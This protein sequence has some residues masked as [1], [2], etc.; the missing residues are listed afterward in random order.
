Q[1]WDRVAIH[2][3]VAT[4]VDAILRKRD[5]GVEERWFDELGEVQRERKVP[6]SPQ[7]TPESKTELQQEHPPKSIYPFGIDRSRLEKAARKIHV[8]VK[9]VDSLNSAD[10]LM[11]TKNH[12]RRNPQIL[13]LAEASKIPVYVIR[14][15]SPSQIELGLADL[16]DVRE[17][18]DPAAIAL[19]EAEE[20]V[21]A[22]KEGQGP[23]EL[24]PQNSFIRRLQH[25]L[26]ENHELKS[27]ST[28]KGPQ[29]RVRVYEQ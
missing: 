29:R 23:M 5:T 11:I 14:S 12:Y 10:M 2:P 18:E 7:K 4:V 3:D 26:I 6:S 20:A 16:Y 1:S 22:I 27:E 25:Q 21:S 15:N 9:L 17:A 19:K 8:P 13:E 24:H 28:G